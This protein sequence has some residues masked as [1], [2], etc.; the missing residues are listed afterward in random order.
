[1]ATVGYA[2][3]SSI[4]QNLD[5]QLGKLREYGCE[6]IFQEKRS[7]RTAARP[8]LK[9]CLRYVRRGDVLVI[10]RL[11]RLARS[12]LDLHRILE[13]LQENDVG[14]VALDQA[15][16]TTTSAGKL[17]FGILA[18]VAEFE[19][20]L[21]KERQAEGISRARAEGVRFGPLPKLT[22][23]KVAELRR[24]RA[25]GVRT[26]DLAEKYGLSRASVYRLLQSADD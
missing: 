2:R 8:A 20:H 22:E 10:T 23:D 25:A 3:V 18:A 26:R 21:R 19:T 9:E 14:F 24:E 7:G 4:G 11:D 17:V 15:I 12:T 16:D 6:E 13:Q 1:M 5:L